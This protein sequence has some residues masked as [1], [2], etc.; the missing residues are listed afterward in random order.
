[1]KTPAKNTTLRRKVR[2]ARSS[3]TVWFSA[4]V[5]ALLAGA[6]ALKENLPAIGEFLHGWKLVTLSVLV[7]VTVAALRVRKEGQDKDGGQ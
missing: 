6:E 4:A 7:S 3:L 5:P 2:A 1:M